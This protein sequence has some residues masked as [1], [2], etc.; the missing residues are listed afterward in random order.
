MLDER[1]LTE[2]LQ[3]Q[4]V[5]D[6]DDLV[7]LLKETASRFAEQPPE[8]LR[9]MLRL[10]HNL[11]GS[12][13]LCGFKDFG[14][15][16]HD[17]ESVFQDL[18]SRI[19]TQDHE[20]YLAPDIEKIAIVLEEQYESLKKHKVIGEPAHEVWK[21]LLAKLARYGSLLPIRERTPLIT[22]DSPEDND[23]K[24]APQSSDG[25]QGW[26]LFGGDPKVEPP[27]DKLPV[28]K[29]IVTPESSQTAYLVCIKDGRRFALPAHCVQEILT[30][31][32]CKSLPVPRL[33]VIGVIPFRGAILPII[34]WAKTRQ[35]SQEQAAFLE[36]SG[37]KPISRCI[38]VCQHA[39]KNFGLQMD[40][41][42]SVTKVEAS[43]LQPLAEE[44]KGDGVVHSL[45]VIDGT[46]VSFVDLDHVIACG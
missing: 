31:R 34:S 20:K 24:I 25:E 14:Q 18:A 1:Q 37:I 7:G 8:A 40:H 16:M 2:M 15:C 41:V 29:M 38:V 26:G 9:G 13:Q 4:F 43:L 3:T 27:K 6:G 33:K 30:D 45:A 42:L 35:G 39:A 44:I 36:H 12:A 28:E 23:W 32:G 10:L 5:R 21:V 19:L 46:T 22:E 17:L 11:K